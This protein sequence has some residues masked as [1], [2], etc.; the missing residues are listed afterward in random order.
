M[1]VTLNRLE[2][3]YPLDGSPVHTYLVLTLPSGESVRAQV[4]NESAEA[5]I[6]A[7][8]SMEDEPEQTQVDAPHFEEVG[9]QEEPEEEQIEWMLLPDR[10]LAP[11]YKQIMKDIGTPPLLTVAAFDNLT[12]EI[13]AHLQQQQQQGP[14]VAPAKPEQPVAA[15]ATPHVVPRRRRVEMDELGYPIV[16]GLKQPRETQDSDEDG[17]AQL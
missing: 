4:S 9:H 14:I 8:L 13:T 1:Q 3:S 6:K 17:V 10:V 7:S 5:L 2:Q 12:D 15:E 11:V 16:P